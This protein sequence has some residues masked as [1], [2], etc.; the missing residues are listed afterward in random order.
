M[1]LKT[2]NELREDVAWEMGKRFGEKGEQVFCSF[3]SPPTG[4][5]SVINVHDE[6][7]VLLGEVDRIYL[8]LIKEAYEL[9]HQATRKLGE[10]VRI[11]REMRRGN[12][13]K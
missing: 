6:T 9:D 2:H 7:K 8:S 1:D 4:T 11:M 10:A 12:D 3:V 13:G 5:D